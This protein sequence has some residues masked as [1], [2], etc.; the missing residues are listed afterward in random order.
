MYLLDTDVISILQGRSQPA[1]G[2][3]THRMGQR[4]RTDFY[5]SVVSLH[6]QLTGAHAF[7]NSARKPADLAHGYRFFID[8]LGYYCHEQV[9]P[10][11]LPSASLAEQLASG[12]SRVNKMDL[13]IASIALARS[14]TLLTRNLRHFSRVPN[15]IVEDWTA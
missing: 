13:R 2:R 3:L 7:I 9:L 14:F 10:F 8:A 6:E 5:V 11:D 15:L 4:R 1:Y 12:K